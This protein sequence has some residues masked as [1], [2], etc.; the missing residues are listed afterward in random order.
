MTARPVDLRRL[1]AEAAAAIGR[2]DGQAALS[3]LRALSY[4]RPNDPAVWMYLGEAA[5][6]A[7]DDAT[8]GEAADRLLVLQPRTVRALVWKGDVLERAGDGRLAA[9]FY[10]RAV[11]SA[12]RMDSVPTS[13]QPEIDR[14]R[15]AVERLDASFAGHLDRNLAPDAGPRVRRAADILAG[16]ATIHLQQ[17]TQFYLPGLAQREFFE[18]D[19]FAW[20]GEVELAT[21]AIRAELG[22]ALGVSE[23]FSPY[24]TSDHGGVPRDRTAVT[25]SHDWSALHLM[26]SGEVRPDMAARF[27]ATLAALANAP[28]CRV[29]GRAPTIMFSLLKAGARIPPHHG[30]MNARLICHLPL[31]VPGEGKL[32]V[33]GEARGWTEGQLL[34][35]DDSIEH[36]AWNDADQNRV[37][38]I[39]D[40]W[41]PDV[42]DE[43]RKGVASVF[44]AVDSYGA[45]PA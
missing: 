24:L 1:E 16:R 10:G 41:R 36:E 27:P 45:D 35:F 21:P 7:G 3:P 39:F 28:L 29:R 26:D 5:R 31:L 32:R 38:L 22:A 12:G 6:L 37:V 18:R 44:G 15:L 42:T 11:E 20:A 17:P 9:G 34:I 14:A 19:E 13:L 8:L 4:H 33:G 40:V 23:L 43:E 25:D 30:V 2:G